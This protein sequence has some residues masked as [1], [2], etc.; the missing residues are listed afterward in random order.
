M[1]ER[2]YCFSFWIPLIVGPV[3]TLHTHAWTL[4]HKQRVVLLLLQGL[5]T[6]QCLYSLFFHHGFNAP[7]D[8]CF[9]PISD[10]DKMVHSVWEM[11]NR[12]IVVCELLE[13]P[14]FL[15]LSTPW[16]GLT[17][18]LSPSLS[19]FTKSVQFPSTLALKLGVVH[20]VS[21]HLHDR[22]VRR[23]RSQG[24]RSDLKKVPR[25][26]RP[27]PFSQLLLP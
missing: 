18:A 12:S 11:L 24:W 10:S 4:P 19:A 26:S 21:M 27:T 5:S 13:N 9:P 2:V 8:N 16:N 6:R 20:L 22:R 23:E 7:L 3:S 17:L 25:P 1:I 14:A 15:L